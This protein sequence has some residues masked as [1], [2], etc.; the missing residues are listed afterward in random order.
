[1]T[2]TKAVALMILCAGLWSMGGVVSRHFE[3]AGGWEVTFWRSF[4]AALTVLVIGL[5]RSGVQPLRELRRAPRMVWASGVLWAVMFTCFMLALSLTRVANVLITQSLAPVVTALLAGVLLGQRVAPR[6]WAVIAVAALG[7]ASMYVF[8]VS[9]LDGR[10]ALGVLVA[11]GIPLAGGLNWVLLQRAG[12]GPDLSMAVLIGGTISAA[13]TLPLA[14]PW[15]ASAHDLVLLA[16][17]GVFQLGIPCML[18]MHVARH[19]SA[20][21]TS[22]LALLEI[23]FGIALT[24]AFGGEKPGIATLLGG[25]AVL[26]A[27]AYHEWSR[28]RLQ[29]SPQRG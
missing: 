14:W 4:F 28:T 2:H 10:H 29:T 13:L 8:D 17:L 25:S 6:T 27:L 5:A 7:I 15:Q 11:L 24:W 3:S 26:G 19:L 22:L 9:E 16:V 23:V 1:M 12:K 21:E 18:V 20:T